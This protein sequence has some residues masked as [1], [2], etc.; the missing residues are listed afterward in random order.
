L[1]TQGYQLDL[2]LGPEFWRLPHGA[3]VAGLT[4]CDGAD[5][6]RMG[7]QPLKV[8]QGTVWVQRYGLRAAAS[9]LV[10]GSKL[11]DAVIPGLLQPVTHP[12]HLSLNTVTN[13]YGDVA[14]R[15]HIT[16]HH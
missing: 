3:T 13:T 16:T 14:F 5:L 12:E 4:W 7:P 9:L 10:P 1:H 11:R 6:L 8:P 15:T 2:N